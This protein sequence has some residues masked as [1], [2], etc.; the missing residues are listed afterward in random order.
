MSHKVTPEKMPCFVLSIISPEAEAGA[1]RRRSCVGTWNFMTC[2]GQ[3]QDQSGRSL[4]FPIP[5]PVS[6]QQGQHS[7]WHP[8]P[9][10]SLLLNTPQM[11]ESVELS[12]LGG[13]IWQEIN[14]L[15]PYSLR[16]EHLY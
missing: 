1:R 4:G 5:Y 16:G 10:L 6:V 14:F 12:L 11:M 13:G 8:P 9:P 15:A 7:A 3:V 2:Q